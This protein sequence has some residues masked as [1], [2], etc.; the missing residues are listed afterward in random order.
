MKP[1]KFDLSNLRLESFETSAPPPKGEGV[2]VAQTVWEG[3]P[4]GAGLQDT[5]TCPDESWPS[6][7]SCGTTCAEEPWTC[8]G[9]CGEPASVYQTVCVTGCEQCPC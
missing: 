3:G 5:T 9:T 4:G 2:V 8:G 7:G 6:W 1:N